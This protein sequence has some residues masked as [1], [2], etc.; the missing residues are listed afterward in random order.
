V[1][2]LQILVCVGAGNFRLKRKK[3]KISYLN[4]T[5]L[6]VFGYF[7]WGLI[8]LYAANFLSHKREAAAKMD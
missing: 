4:L 1:T 8:F 5:S 6:S 7:M 2:E 3:T